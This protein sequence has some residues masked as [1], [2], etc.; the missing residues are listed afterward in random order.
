MRPQVIALSALAAFAGSA[1]AQQARFEPARDVDTTVTRPRVSIGGA[2]TQTYQSL[3]HGN[4][5]TPATPANTP[6]QIRPGF[7]LAT[8]NLNIEAKVFP[9]V[10][11]VVEN[12]MSSRHHQEFWVKGG[13][14]Q[15]DVSPI[16]H[17]LLHR[18]ME[19]T[20][21]RAGMYEPNYGD[22]HYRRS[23]NGATVQ[24]AF[25]EN[26]ILDAFTTEIGADATVRVGP[27]LAVAGITAGQNNG[28]IKTPLDSMD[29]R[30]AF[31]G[32]LGFDTNLGTRMGP[33]RVRL[34][35]STYR[36]SETIRPTLFAGDRTG[37]AFHGVLQN[38][39]SLADTKS[40]FT[41]GRVSPSFG[42]R[43]TAYQV[44]PFVQ[45]G[46]LELFGVY[47]TAKGGPRGRDDTADVRQL[48]GEAIY[49]L[50]P[51]YL[52]ARHNRVTGQVNAAVTDAEVTRNSV[53]AGW[54][55]F[56]GM[57]LK[58]EYLK[59]TYDGWAETDI[60]HG[61]RFD[62]VVIQAALSF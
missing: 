32:K 3:E 22:Q 56:P 40:P 45:I 46:G 42:N 30:P 6:G 38:Q 41:N 25:T 8:A 9:G 2:F 39:A 16:D 34:T 18:V 59:Q 53:V 33:A 5:A 23:D 35:G 43:L 57:A 28:D 21:I 44:N 60:L 49:R 7:N 10:T 50:G 51:V 27:F 37:S 54:N 17:P 31:V 1:G 26:L 55:V 52:G 62:G 58:A 29:F 15:V 13:Y 24:N 12:Y 47:E 14:A 11:V 61:G 48:S 4:E 20:S 36:V 19:Y